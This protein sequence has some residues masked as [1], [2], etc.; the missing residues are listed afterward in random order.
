MAHLWRLDPTTY[1]F[2]RIISASL[3]AAGQAFLAA[4]GACA[5]HPSNV[6]LLIHVVE[7]VPGLKVVYDGESFLFIET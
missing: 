3:L 6:N 2:L 4:G 7:T 1:S 5:Q